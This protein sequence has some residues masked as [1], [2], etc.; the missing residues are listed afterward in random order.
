MNEVAKTGVAV[1]VAVVLGVLAASMGPREV[2]LEAFDDQGKEFFPAFKD[3]AAATELQVM[4]FREAEGTPYPFVVKRDDKGR[5]T[6][7]SHDNYP[8]DAKDRMGKAAA[9]LIGL[10]KQVVVGDVKGDHARYGL[11]DP[12]DP[13]ADAA[14]RGKRLTMKDSAGNVLADLIIGKEVEGKPQEHFVRVPEKKRVYRVK[15]DSE[16]S[17]KFADWIETDLLKASSWDIT[18]VTF[19]N[20]SVNEQGRTLQEAIVP[21]DKY[22]VTK[23]NAGK[24]SVQG[25]D[26]AKEEPNEEKLR[27]IGDTLGSIKIVGVR[28]KPEGLTAALEQATGRDRSII[29][30]LLQPLGFFLATNGKMYSNEGDL[31]FETKKGVR[32]TLRFG[33][34][35]PGEGDEVS[36]GKPAAPAKP[37]DKPKAG[38]PAPKPSNNRYLMVTTA[39]VEDALDKPAGTR[40]AKEQIDK[41]GEAR[42]QIEA[43]QRALEAYRSKNENKLP[44]TLGKLAEK[45]AEGDALLKELKKDPWGN[46]YQLQVQGETYAVVSFAEGGAEGGEGVAADVRSDRL[47]LEDEL[48]KNADAW[49][50]HDRKVEE[51]KKEAEKLTRRFGPWYYVI[52]QALFAKLK[53]KRE[54][55]VKPKAPPAPA[56]GEATVPGTTPPAGT[57]PG[58]TTPPGGGTAHEPPK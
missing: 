52:D 48:K 32:Y 28:Q 5:W 19:D 49:A 38:E 54:D 35:V 6:I 20:Y 8:A 16:V 31:L 44:D 43:I 15:I 17:T 39:F 23:D 27:E 50:D 26:A 13:S 12:L 37:G 53:P 18:K 25:M 29:A 42:T 55:L 10:K 7:P 2:R 34:L 3:P 21:G 24:W 33:E 22:V 51:G 9:L 45:P 4:E 1:G 41:R 56:P 11:V 30:Q 57:T 58:T 46:D 36:S 40:L 47:P 14:G